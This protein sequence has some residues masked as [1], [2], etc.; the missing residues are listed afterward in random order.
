E[1]PDWSP[2]DVRY[3]VIRYITTDI[4]NAQGPHVHD[5]RTG[6]ILESDILW[7]HNVMNLLRNW[8]LIQTAAVNPQARSVKFEK[9]VMG[10]LIRFVSAHEV[11]HTLGL[12]HNMGSSVAYPVDSLRSPGFVQRMGTAPS[13]MDYA[14]F[15]Y[16]AQPEDEGAGLHPRIGPYDRWAIMYGYKLNLEADDPQEDKDI[17]NDWILDRA[18]NPIYRYG[19]GSRVDPSSQTEDLGHDAM[20]ASELGIANL[21]RIVPEL[22]D[23]TARE[24]ENYEELEEIY[25]NVLSQFRRYMGHVT[26][27]VG[28]V[29]EYDKT[30]EQEGSVYTHVNR[31]KQA[32]AVA[33]LNQQL[34]V[35]PGWMID[36]TILSRIEASGMMDRL[37]RLQVG[38][39]NALYD[40]DRLKRLIE[41]EAMHGARAYRPR[42]LFADTRSGIWSEIRSEIAIDPYRRNLQR[43]YIDKMAELM[44][45][46]Q[47]DYHQTDIK[48]LARANLKMLR[49]DIAKGIKRQD[50]Q[51]SRMHLEDSLARIDRILD[52]ES[53]D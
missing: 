43:A 28:G 32:R 5:P 50:D 48:P 52:S 39:L 7:Y 18:S 17:L 41:G 6:E 47:T 1:D 16:V 13:I 36:T 35:T 34:F 22:M 38:T 40:G 53:D 3:S 9:E 10:E 51:M 14:R 42:D 24:G 2:E 11:G 31:Q 21:K 25:G 30:Y 29:Y 33:F 26:T 45:D 49:E 27:N 19:Q 37:R 46:E 23:W 15:N 20:Y 12:P 4:Q 44:D 8:Y